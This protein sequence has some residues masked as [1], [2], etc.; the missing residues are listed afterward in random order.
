MKYEGPPPED[1]GVWPENWQTVEV[2]AAMG[3][4]WNRDAHGR[5]CGLRY[6]VL[7]TVEP[8]LGVKKSRRAG[9]FRNLRIMEVAALDLWSKH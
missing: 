8:R 7:P 2:F 4:Q 3:T 9:V 5:K 1:F 6:E